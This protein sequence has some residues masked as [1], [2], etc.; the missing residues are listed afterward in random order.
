MFTCGSF[1]EREVSEKFRLGFKFARSSG[2]LTS[3]A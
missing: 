3:D 2:E 1:Q